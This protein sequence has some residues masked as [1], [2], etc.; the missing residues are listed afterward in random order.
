MEKE[1]KLKTEQKESARE[2][3]ELQARF[4]A[5]FEECVKNQIAAARKGYEA[6]IK[7]GIMRQKE[8][9]PL[10]E[11]KQSEFLEMDLR[12][13]MAW[14]VN[15]FHFWW[16]GGWYRE[17]LRKRAVKNNEDKEKL[18]ADKQLIKDV[19]EVISKRGYQSIAEDVAKDENIDEKTRLKTL[20]D[21]Y[22]GMREKGY[23]RNRLAA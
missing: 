5:E 2:L 4:D 12:A 23:N 19:D 3:G 20:V 14:L 7:M 9:E 11:K 15:N 1:L 16:P 10:M 21:V 17:L 6:A 22:L 18:A 8:L 13:R